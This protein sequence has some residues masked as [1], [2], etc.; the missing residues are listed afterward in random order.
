LENV[1]GAAVLLPSNES[2][3]ISAEE[4][5]AM[6]AAAIAN[7]TRNTGPRG[8]LPVIV[9]AKPKATLRSGPI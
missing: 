2:I 8:N 4:S 1:Q 7:V 9:L 5:A 6:Q 3:R